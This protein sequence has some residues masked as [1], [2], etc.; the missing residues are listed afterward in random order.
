[1]KK[2]LL[3]TASLNLTGI[4]VSGL[5]PPVHHQPWPTTLINSADISAGMSVNWSLLILLWA[6]GSAAIWACALFVCAGVTESES[7]ADREPK[8]GR[9]APPSPGAG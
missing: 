2:L 5:F 6:V 4:A 1:M 7:P 9:P 8:P 3:R